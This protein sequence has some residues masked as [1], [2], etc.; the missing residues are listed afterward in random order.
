M[1]A[2]RV[3]EPGAQ[4]RL[5]DRK[6]AVQVTLYLHEDDQ[7]QHRSLYLEVLRYLDDEKGAGAVDYH[8]VAGVMGRMRLKTATLVDAGGP[9]KPPGAG[10]GVGSV[11]AGAGDGGGPRPSRPGGRRCRSRLR[12][13]RQ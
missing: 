11:K 3:D 1:S 10:L 5:G 13:C 4:P 8:T 9:V 2:G 6:M 12:R 7:W